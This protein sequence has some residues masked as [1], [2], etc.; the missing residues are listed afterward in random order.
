MRFRA[1]LAGSLL[2][3]GG[4]ALGQGCGGAVAP[5]VGGDGG[6]AGSSGGSSSGGQDGGTTAADTGVVDSATAMDSPIIGS[7]EPDGVPCSFAAQCCTGVCAGGVCGGTTPTCTGDGSPCASSTECCSSMCAGGFCEA[8]TTSCAV[9]SN[10][11][12]CD[13]CLADSCCSQLSACESNPTC[14]ESQS[15]FDACYTGPGSGAS[16]AQ[17]CGMEFPS[18]EGALLEQCAA[19]VCLTDCN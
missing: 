2:L 9:S 4:C 12:E 11:N 16:C 8:T 3:V 18:T 15:C 6:V 14:T 10:A 5:V 13:I 1:S 17:K 7:C 19:S